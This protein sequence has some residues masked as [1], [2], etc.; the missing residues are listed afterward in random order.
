MKQQLINLIFSLFFL[1][2]I[3]NLVQN[4]GKSV[5]SSREFSMKSCMRIRAAG[6]ATRSTSAC[7]S[8]STCTSSGGVGSVSTLSGTVRIEAIIPNIS[9]QAVQVNPIPI[10][11]TPLAKLLT[12]RSS[13]I[14]GDVPK[15]GYLTLNQVRKLVTL[16]ETDTSVPLVPLVGVWVNFANMHTEPEIA[17]TLLEHPFVWGAC[18]RFLCSDH[19]QERVHV[20]RDTFLLVSKFCIVLTLKYESIYAMYRR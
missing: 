14:A 13:S 19:V 20:A 18:V 6:G 5:R 12:S 16:Q 17:A 8:S 15:M 11:A 4:L 2:V 7:K 10:L 1:Y 3:S 9:F